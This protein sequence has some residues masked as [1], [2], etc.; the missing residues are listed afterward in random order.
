VLFRSGRAA[1][2]EISGHY[3]PKAAVKLR[4]RRF[5][6]RCFVT[7]GRRLILPAFGAY[8]GGLDVLDPAVSALFPRGFQVHLL[9]PGNV[10][11]FPK[12]TLRSQTGSQTVSG[13]FPVSAP[14]NVR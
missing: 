13:T 12:T 7:D 2:G 14:G 9:G 1:P 3:H 6:G 5:T 10:Y 4:A 8:A 11:R